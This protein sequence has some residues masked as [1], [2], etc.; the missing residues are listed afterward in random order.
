[1]PGIPAGLSDLLHGRRPDSS[2]CQLMPKSGLSRAHLVKYWSVVYA[3]REIIVLKKTSGGLG[4][5][6]RKLPRGPDLAELHQLLSQCMEQRGKVVKLAW[7]GANLMPF[8]LEVVCHLKNGNAQWKLYTDAGKVLFDYTSVD[9]LL[10]Y[11]LVVSNCAEAQQSRTPSESQQRMPAYQ[12]LPP[13]APMPPAR[14]ESDYTPPA[15]KPIAPPA[16]A[17]TDINYQADPRLPQVKYPEPNAEKDHLRDMDH[18]YRLKPTEVDRPL[19]VQPGSSSIEKAMP[20]PGFVAV[21]RP[22]LLPDSG[23]IPSEGTISGASTGELLREILKAGVTGRLDIR[24]GD[25]TATVFVQEGIPIDATANDVQ[26]DEA[27]IE[28][29]TWR[30]GS[31][32]F[33]PRILR[34]N[35]TVYES[36]ESLVEQSKQLT[37]RIAYLKNAGMVPSSTVMPTNNMISQ[38]DF[39]ARAQDNCPSD[40]DTVSRVYCS[41]DGKRTFEELCRF[42]HLSRI[43]MVNIIFH[44]MVK[45]L[46]KVYNPTR[47]KS[48]LAFSPKVIDN[49]AIQSIMMS[50]RRADTGLFI[51]PAFLYFLEQEY[52]RS[53]RSRT[54][55][56][57]VVFELRQ[58]RI[59]DGEVARRVLSERALMD[60]VLRISKIKRHVD[61]ISHYEAH[62]YAL[63]LPSTRSQGAEIFV[64]RVIEALM[65]RPLGGEVMANQLALAFGVAAIPDDFRDMASLLGGADLAMAQAKKTDKPMVMYRDIK[66]MIG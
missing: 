50:L 21:P 57:V 17:E 49:A 3:T 12:Q 34:N 39:L 47:S 32:S 8:T 11:N 41:L 6:L 44:L 13:P 58:K 48:A 66:D 52:F 23:S 14:Q 29:L 54:S 61:L 9:V 42:L 37:D 18:S 24:S 16:A 22:A 38:G 5:Q 33:E 35:H 19:I 55:F 7:R 63:L 1:M 53:Y 30:D 31:F 64:G 45:E 65:E 4:G 36:I 26:G 25:L 46:V 60:A 56:S 62:D 10:V 2:A 40:I 20:T 43:Q 51:Y 59:I 27:M 15:A 28:M